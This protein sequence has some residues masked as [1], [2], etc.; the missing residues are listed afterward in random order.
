MCCHQEELT[1]ACRLSEYVYESVKWLKQEGTN[2][3]KHDWDYF[4]VYSI[5]IAR[6]RLL[7]IGHPH[8]YMNIALIYKKKQ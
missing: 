5:N 4:G 6:L 3:A 8:R 1:C 7:S 2:G